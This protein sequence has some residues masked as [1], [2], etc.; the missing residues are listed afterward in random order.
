[1][2]QQKARGTA[3]APAAESMTLLVAAV[4]VH[5]NDAGRVLLIQR[6]PDAKFSPG[7]W[8]LPSGKNEPGEP[9]TATALRELREETG[10]TVRPEALRPAHVIHCA[11]GVEAPNG[12]LTIVFATREWSGEP[13]NREP[14][15]HAQVRWTDITAI[16][17][18]L[19]SATATALRSYLEHGPGISLEGW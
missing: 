9:V 5:D 16:P 2:A 11:R 19:V 7:H 1:V 8:D 18:Q 6:G 3:L 17:A 10:L 4:I 15:K 13:A 12:F 14:G